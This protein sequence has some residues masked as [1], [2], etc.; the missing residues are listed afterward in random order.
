MVT[1]DLGMAGQSSSERGR[2]DTDRWWASPPGCRGSVILEV[3]YYL[4][5]AFAMVKTLLF[6]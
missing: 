5:E 6:D 2:W 3:N 1:N 4:R